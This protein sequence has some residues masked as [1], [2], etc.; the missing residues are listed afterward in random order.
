M[1]AP[2]ESSRTGAQPRTAAAPRDH[3]SNER[4]V[5]SENEQKQRDAERTAKAAARKRDAEFEAV[6]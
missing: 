3:S 2:I 4:R 6:A 5:N 1:S